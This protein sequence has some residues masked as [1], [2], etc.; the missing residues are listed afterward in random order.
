MWPGPQDTRLENGEFPRPLVV[1]H[2]MEHYVPVCLT[3]SQ[4][5]WAWLDSEE[6]FQGDKE[7]EAA[8]RWVG[9]LGG[10]YP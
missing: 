3:V 9:S 2:S 1:A 4:D 6:M 10:V 8:F 5:F 7:V